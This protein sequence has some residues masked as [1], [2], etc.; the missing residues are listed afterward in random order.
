MYAAGVPLSDER[1]AMGLT[2]EDLSPDDA[3]RFAQYR[4]TIAGWLD[5]MLRPELKPAPE[6]GNSEWRVLLGLSSKDTDLIVGRWTAPAAAG[7]YAGAG[8][9]LR[10]SRQQ[11]YVT[12]ASEALFSLPVKVGSVSTSDIIDTV[13]KVLRPPPTRRKPAIPLQ[14][15]T[16]AGRTVCHGDLTYDWHRSLEA[17]PDKLK[18][19]KWWS[20]IDFWFTQGRAFVS[21]STWNWAAGPPAESESPG[22]PFEADFSTSARPARAD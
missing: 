10:A 6:T 17:D 20:R 3:E 13:T 19:R 16:V 9:E 18:T 11:M 2:E 15:T 7:P 1:W 22:W 21:V 14:V 8:V 12:V 4:S 5:E